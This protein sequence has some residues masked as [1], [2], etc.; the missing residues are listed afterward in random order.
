MPRVKQTEEDRNFLRMVGDNIKFYR[1]NNNCREI[2]TDKYGRVSQEKLAELADVSASMI[3]SLE[4]TNVD[5][6]MSIAC[7]RKVAV[8]LNI[9][10]YAF[11]LERPIKNPPIDPFIDLV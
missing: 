2:D 9:P 10:F 3:S 5:Q 1:I 4:A 6:T 7:L 11:F 8:A